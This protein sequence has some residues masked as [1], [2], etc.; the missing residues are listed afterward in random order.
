MRRLDQ[1]ITRIG[2]RKQLARP[3]AR[4]Q[5]GHHMNIGTRGQ[6]QRN[7]CLIEL[8]LKILNRHTNLRSRIG[9]QP[10]QYV[11]RAGQIG[12]AISNKHACHRQRNRQIGR[13]IIDTRQYVT[14]EIDHI[15][16]QNSIC[17]MLQCTTHS[18]IRRRT[19]RPS[20][21]A[22]TLGI[23]SVRI[24]LQAPPPPKAFHETLSIATAKVR[25]C[26]Q[27][28]NRLWLICTI[29]QIIRQTAKTLY[30][31]SRFGR[32]TA[33]SSLQSFDK[34]QPNT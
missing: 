10:R 7:P 11:R 32:I 12:H 2:E 30:T 6:S 17:L 18:R 14:V 20:R 8:S 29:G 9:V 24:V 4:N 26:A 5:I 15:A 28:T 27:N 23:Y 21:P 34:N 33:A 31:P 16:R 25:L 3:Q 13:P 22:S 1:H 19:Q